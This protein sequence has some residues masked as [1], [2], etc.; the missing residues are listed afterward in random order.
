MNVR[1][2]EYKRAQLTGC[3]PSEGIHAPGTRSERQNIPTPHRPHVP[4]CHCPHLWATAV[5]ISHMREF[6]VLP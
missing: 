1:L 4:A 5:L 2:P 6:Y 3:G